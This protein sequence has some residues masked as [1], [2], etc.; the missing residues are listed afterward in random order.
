MSSAL[1]LQKT[2]FVSK[3]LIVSLCQLAALMFAFRPKQN[4]TKKKS[5]QQPVQKETER[6]ACDALFKDAI[7]E[8]DQTTSNSLFALRDGSTS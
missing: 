3:D 2:F 7:S 6:K 4:K 1:P 8:S 5:T